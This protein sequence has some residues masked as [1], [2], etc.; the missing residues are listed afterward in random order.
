MQ[1]PF[2]YQTSQLPQR[3]N[4]QKLICFFSKI[5]KELKNPFSLYPLQQR[6]NTRSVSRMHFVLHLNNSAC[7]QHRGCHSKWS[8]IP[9]KDISFYHSLLCIVHACFCSTFNI[10]YIWFFNFTFIFIL[11][12]LVTLVHWLSLCWVWIA[13]Y[14]IVFNK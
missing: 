4:L 1:H 6:S 11:Y 10:S 7:A 13:F 9:N 2:L 5:P 14:A 3:W 12:L 8:S